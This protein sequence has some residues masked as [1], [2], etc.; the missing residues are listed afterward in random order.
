MERNGFL[1]WEYYFAFGGGLA[2]VDLGHGAGHGDAGARARRRAGS[3]TRPCTQV[4]A[5]AAGARSSSAR[6]E[7][8]RVPQASG[9]WYALYSFAPQLYVLNGHLQAV[10]GLRTY[11]ELPGRRG[12]ARALP[13]RRRAPRRQRIASFDTGAWSLYCRPSWVTGPEANLNYHTL[14]RDFARNLC[15]GTGEP[16]YCDAADHFTPYLKEDP[17]LDPQRA[18]PSPAV[19]RQGRAVP[20]Q[21]LEDRARRASSCAT[22]GRR[23]SPRARSFAHGERYIRW[24]PPRL[25]QRAHLHVHAVRADLAGNSSSATGEVRVKPARKPPQR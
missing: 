1:A 6:R 23:T 21:A 16:A 14:N 5:R 2:A 24:V 13:G 8:V 25:K 17:T 7:G 22:A 4:A 15:K 19:A 20:V 3:P 10:N 12:G 11:A 9:D 18:V